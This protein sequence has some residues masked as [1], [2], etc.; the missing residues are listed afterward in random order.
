MQDRGLTKGNFIKKSIDLFG[1][2][3]YNKRVKIYFFGNE[4]LFYD[5]RCKMDKMYRGYWYS[6]S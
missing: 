6:F 3:W 4:V 2:I 1:D 5:N